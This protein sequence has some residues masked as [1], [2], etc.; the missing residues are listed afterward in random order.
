MKNNFKKQP[1]QNH[2]E[3]TSSHGRRTKTTWKKVKQ[4]IIFRETEIRSLLIGAHD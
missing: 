2:P 3:A 4:F 1:W